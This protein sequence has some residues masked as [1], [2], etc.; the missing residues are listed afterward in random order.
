[1]RAK[2]IKKSASAANRIMRMKTQWRQ[3]GQQVFGCILQ[4]AWLHIRHIDCKLGLRIYISLG[5][6]WLSHLITVD[7]SN[8]T[9]ICK[10]GYCLLD[11]CTDSII[12]QANRDSK[13]APNGT[14]FA[15][16]T[17]T[18]QLLFLS[19]GS[20]EQNSTFFHRPWHF[21]VHSSAQKRTPVMLALI[22]VQQDEN[23]ILSS[24]RI[25]TT[26]LECSLLLWSR[27]APQFS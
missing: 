23:S 5:M 18:G 17:D 6:E 20:L 4:V 24:S 25:K 26:N 13:F 21:A 22:L 19:Q 1:M 7:V 3:I 2:R 8:A 9:L 14:K 10:Y 16:R 12:Q 11:F 15:P 27:A